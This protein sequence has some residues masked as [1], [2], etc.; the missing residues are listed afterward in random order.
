MSALGG[1]IIRF[2]VIGMRSNNGVEVTA[3]ASH[4]VKFLLIHH[5][6]REGLGRLSTGCSSCRRVMGLGKSRVNVCSAPSGRAPLV[7]VLSCSCCS[8]VII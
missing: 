7:T 4:R 1:N 5:D 3:N 6:P 2:Q 8:F